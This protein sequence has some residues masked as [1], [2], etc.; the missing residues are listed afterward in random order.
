MRCN[1]CGADMNRRD[2]FSDDPWWD[3]PQCGFNITDED[4]EQFGY[5]EDDEYAYSDVFP[6]PEN[7]PTCCLNC[8][9]REEEYPDCRDDCDD[10]VDDNW[11]VEDL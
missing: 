6:N 4:I 11:Y 8:E 7:I 5:D 10:Y 9:R 3:C 1:H 2:E